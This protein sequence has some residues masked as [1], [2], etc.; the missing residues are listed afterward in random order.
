[1]TGR[2]VDDRPA[3]VGA[4]GVLL[5]K[6]PQ[7]A[8]EPHE[9]LLDQV[10]GQGSIARQQEREPDALRRVPDVEVAERAVRDRGLLGHCDRHHVAF[11]PHGT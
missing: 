10:L 1:M 6:V 9:G 4:E 3:K 8:D 11:L 2:E 5:A 7:P